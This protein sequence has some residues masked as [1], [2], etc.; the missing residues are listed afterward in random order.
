MLFKFNSKIFNKVNLLI[1]FANNYISV[2][3]ILSYLCLI[4]KS[5]SNINYVN[6]VNLLIVF[7]NFSRIS[8]SIIFFYKPKSKFNYYKL[9]IFCII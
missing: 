5:N 9:F 8:V 7:D 1:E 6:K 3:L 2:S 4:K